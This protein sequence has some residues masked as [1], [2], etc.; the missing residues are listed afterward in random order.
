MLR[1][2]LAG[3]FLHRISH[4][5]N[6]IV[7]IAGQ[8]IPE[9]TLEWEQYCQTIHLSRLSKELWFEYARRIC[10]ILPSPDYIDAFYEML[11]G[12]PSEMAKALACYMP[13]AAGDTKI[14]DSLNRLQSANSTGE[15][16]WLVTLDLLKSLP[17]N[18]AKLAWAAAI[19]LV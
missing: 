16:N 2:W 13:T 5:S 14:G 11:D 3:D 19:P 10:A 12:Q 18:L 1:V 7:V 15:R 9:P 8:N 6:V 17:A 4:T